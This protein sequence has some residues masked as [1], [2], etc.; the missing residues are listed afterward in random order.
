MK[1]QEKPI[2]FLRKV[3][4]GCVN[5][6]LKTPLKP[7]FQVELSDPDEHVF[8]WNWVGAN[9]AVMAIE[10]VLFFAL[11]LAIEYRVLNY[12]KW[13]SVHLCSLVFSVR[14]MY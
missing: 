9:V 2:V 13:W 14:N 12:F 10:S 3:D 11:N 4:T 7:S 5:D 8:Q 1:K 6:F